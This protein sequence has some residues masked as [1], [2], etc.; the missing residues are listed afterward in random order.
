MP[1]P[2]DRAAAVTMVAP[3]RAPRGRRLWL[4][5]GTVLDVER[6]EV[7]E[8]QYVKLVSS[9]AATPEGSVEVQLADV[10]AVL[11]NPGRMIP[12][13]SLR[14]TRI[15]G[16]PT[17][18]RCPGPALESRPAPLELSSIEYRGP[19]VVH[20]QKL[21]RVPLPEPGWREQQERPHNTSGHDA[22]PA[23]SF[24]ARAADT[25]AASRSDSSLACSRP[26]LV[27]L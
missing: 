11:F 21:S 5:D 4:R 3:R 20:R 6:I 24:L 9:S 7:S 1:I 10:V 16:P 23:S 18:Y 26:S 19:L 2:L 17:R 8:D 22:P 25:S 15:D 27:S 14:P 12:L 13:A